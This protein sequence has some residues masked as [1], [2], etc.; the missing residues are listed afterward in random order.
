MLILMRQW[1]GS[2]PPWVMRLA[3][4]KTIDII[5]KRECDLIS[6]V[7]KRPVCTGE[8]MGC[9]SNIASG[10]GSLS[11]LHLQPGS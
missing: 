10:T 9:R 2:L 8:H 1:A 11:G 6:W 3:S 5:Q 4:G 7:P